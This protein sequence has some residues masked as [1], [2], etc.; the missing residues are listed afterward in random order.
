MGALSIVWLSYYHDSPSRYNVG[1]QAILETSTVAPSL[2]LVDLPSLDDTIWKTF[3]MAIECSH[4]F[5]WQW[6]EVYNMLRGELM[7]QLALLECWSSWI[8]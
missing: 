7:M 6:L 4:L 5:F 2:P 8:M 1:K 3:E